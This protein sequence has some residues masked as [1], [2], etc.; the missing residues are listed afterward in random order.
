MCKQH[1][2]SEIKSEGVGERQNTNV[3]SVP[4]LMTPGFA[5]DSVLILPTLL[6]SCCRIVALIQIIQRSLKK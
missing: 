1:N 4:A 3:P 5:K 6:D 2:L